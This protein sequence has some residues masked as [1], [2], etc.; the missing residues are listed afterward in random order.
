MSN[1]L[2]RPF[3]PIPYFSLTNP[4]WA[5]S[6]KVWDFIRPEFRPRNSA[7][8]FLYAT[9]WELWRFDVHGAHLVRET[10]GRSHLFE[11]RLAVK[12]QFKDLQ[13]EKKSEKAA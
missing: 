13:K 11:F 12:Q 5:N 6:N 4:Y 3:L 1:G 10:I 7:R 2:G 9:T 8:D